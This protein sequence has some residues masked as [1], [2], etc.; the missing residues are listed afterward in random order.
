MGTCIICDTP[1]DGEVCEFHEEDVCFLFR[2]TDASQLTP[3]RY[4]EGTVD[5]Y[6]D[7]GVF[8]DIG[9]RVTGLL[10]RSELDKRLES[11]DWEPGDTVFVQVLDVR[12][13]GNVDLG[14]SI[15]QGRDEFRGCVVDDPDG[16]RRLDEADSID[17]PD[18]SA[19]ETTPASAETDDESTGMTEQTETTTGTDSADESAATGSS[20][21]GTDEAAG[22]GATV[23]S[24]NGGT[25]AVVAESD[26]STEAAADAELARTTVDALADQVGAIVRLDGV[27]TGV[28]QTTGPTIFELRDET[29][30]I[31][32]AAFEEA[33]VRA[34]P[35]VDLDDVVS[36]EGEVER[37]NGDLQIETESLTVLTDDERQAVL[38][39]HEAAIEDEAR[40]ASVDPLGGHETVD[41]LTDE[42]TEAATTI[43][44]AVMEAR[45]I[46]VRHSDTADG[47][48]A[49]AAIEHALLPLIEDKHTRDD[50]IYHYVTRRPLEG[51]VYDM[52]DAT[53]D[54]SNMLDARDRHGEQLPLV[55]VVDAGSTI[56]STDAYELLAQYGADRLV[57]DANVA[58]S[59]VSETVRTAV[60]PGDRDETLTT[61]AIAATL[62]AAV[63]ADV[64]EDL[65]HLPALSYWESP[66][67][68]YVDLASE[69][70]FDADA[71]ADRRNAVALEAHYQSYNDKRE[72]IAD[73]LFDSNGGLAGH[74]GDQFR[75]KLETELATARENTTVSGTGDVTVTVLDTA[76]FTHRYDFPPTGLLLDALHRSERDR[77]DGPFA[78]LGVDEAELSVRTTDFVD[79]RDLGDAIATAVPDAGVTVV[80]GADGT[81][82]FLK[83]ERE[84]V[85]DAA[86]D[87]LGDLLE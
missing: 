77:A 19:D 83:G 24:T 56:E 73:L 37:H 45:P 49:G 65:R 61:T 8:V 63:N 2:G 23:G 76:Q 39:R 48:V 33:G 85:Q 62:A 32:C 66:P 60:T 21:A 70:G 30:T 38:D 78:T 64:R 35:D 41:G 58:D 22:D 6:A 68:S 69:A 51:T 87:A 12:D 67:E 1:V 81:V 11:L 15:R 59:A 20:S 36:I 14:W 34:Y 10:H 71:L 26:E 27:V 74:V 7:F 57:V 52:D 31:E 25:A 79:V 43:R 28:R 18:G 5:G 72:L 13:N 82:E 29:G 53:G 3:R 75:E 42:L 17:E 46:V 16:E 54:V 84:A 9:P 50:A 86:V 47:Y 44:R 4:Y 40:P 80:G 55:V